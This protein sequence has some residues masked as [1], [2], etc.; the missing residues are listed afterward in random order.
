MAKKDTWIAMLLAIAVSI[1]LILLYAMLV[2]RYP[3]QTLF[4]MLYTAFG[5]K[6]GWV[7]TLLTTVYCF[8]LG[9]MVL[10]DF[11]E[12][13]RATALQRTPIVIFTLLISLVCAYLVRLGVRSFGKAGIL[14]VWIVGIIVI[15]T[16]F[17]L[18]PNMKP[19]H[20]RPVLATPIPTIAWNTGKLLSSPFG[21]TVLLLCLYA[22]IKPGQNAKKPFAAGILL[23]GS[24]LLLSILRNILVLGAE[25]FSS[26]YFPS[27]SAVSTINIGDFLQRIEVMVAGYLL[28]CDIMKISVA[29]Y[30][31]CLGLSKLLKLP[32]Y[33]AVVLPAALLMA[34][35]SVLEFGS[36]MQFYYWNPFYILLAV[37]FQL[38]I[39]LL[40]WITGFFRNRTK[41]NS[42]NNLSDI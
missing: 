39:P 41:R 25:N 30:A 23:G 31:T 35:L 27:Y 15:L 14:F 21:E 8:Q 13:V 4:D 16:I 18:I 6:I 24:Y 20:I 2:K 9:V 38:L 17:F 37:P 22:N 10:R 11:P 12:F 26:L 1:P 32:D 7:V 29:M 40:L 34:A 36:I 28:I 3:G 5:K 33:R 19:N 42:V